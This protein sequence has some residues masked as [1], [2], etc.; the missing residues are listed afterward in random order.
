MLNAEAGSD[1]KQLRRKGADIQTLVKHHQSSRFN[2]YI[3]ASLLVLGCA[4]ADTVQL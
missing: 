3:V 4:D 2:S 1:L